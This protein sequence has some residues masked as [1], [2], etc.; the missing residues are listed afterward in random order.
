MW[1]DLHVESIQGNLNKMA[2]I[3]HAATFHDEFLNGHILIRMRIWKL[4]MHN[5]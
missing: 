1:F 5:L 2:A 4:L 3:F